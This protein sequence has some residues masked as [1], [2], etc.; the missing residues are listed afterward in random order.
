MRS[1]FAF[2]SKERM[3]QNN[4]VV[5]GTTPIAAKGEGAILYFT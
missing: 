3:L 2:I 4:Q 5:L 1:S